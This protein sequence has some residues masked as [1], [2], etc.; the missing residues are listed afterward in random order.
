MQAWVHEYSVNSLEALR[1]FFWGNGGGGVADKRKRG[2]LTPK[3]VRHHRPLPPPVQDSNTL[4]NA[5]YRRNKARR[6]LELNSVGDD[7]PRSGNRLEHWRPDTTTKRPKIQLKKLYFHNKGTSCAIY[8]L[9]SPSP[10]FRRP[11]THLFKETEKIS[12][13]ER[14]VFGRTS[15]KALSTLCRVRMS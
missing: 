12:K 1:N 6:E 8:S 15:S 3:T 9:Q 10:I 11:G 14:G 2:V 13:A 4:L 7:G 5:F